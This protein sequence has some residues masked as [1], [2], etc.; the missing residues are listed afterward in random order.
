MSFTDPQTQ[1]AKVALRIPP[2]WKANV[3]LWIAQCDNAFTYSGIT[4]D[5]TKFSA[6]VAN[7][8]GETLSHV[9][10]IVLNPP[11][12]DKYKK[13]S[14]RLINEFADS[15]QQKIKKLLT[16]LQLG[17]ERPSHLL[18]KMKELSGT[19]LTDDFLQNLWMQRMPTHIQ[20]VLSAS[21]EK[22]DQLAVIADKVA[23]V[24]QPSAICATSAAG[25]PFDTSGATIDTLTKKID[26]LTRQVSELSRG[27]TTTRFRSRSNSRSRIGNSSTSVCFYHNR[28]GDKALKC[29][30]PCN[31]QKQKNAVLPS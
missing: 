8:D 10:D 15:E 12:T 13:L 4:N 1:V 16:E 28:F 21:S 27:R 24:V 19:Q 3:R 14:E 23:E 31:Y 5:E 25:T 17:D 18:R 2:F 9:S 26:E 29:A 11:D 6:L 20:T 30:K 7:I 22:L